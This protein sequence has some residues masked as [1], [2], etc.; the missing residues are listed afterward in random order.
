[1]IFPVTHIEMLPLY[2]DVYAMLPCTA[3]EVAAQLEITSNHANA[4]LYYLLEK[5]MAKRTRRFVG[6]GNTGR[7]AHRSRLWERA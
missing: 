5:K 2:M 1:M 6:N 4:A 3:P 7:G